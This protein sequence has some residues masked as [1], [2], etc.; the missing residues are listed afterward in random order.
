V[1]GIFLFLNDE[2]IPV[3]IELFSALFPANKLAGHD[4]ATEGDHRK[5]V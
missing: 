3:L 2:D 5:R 1:R 4:T